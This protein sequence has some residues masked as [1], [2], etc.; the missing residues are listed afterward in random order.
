MGHRGR[1]LPPAR[2]DGPGECRARGLSARRRP[3]PCI[4][5]VT[6]SIRQLGDASARRRRT[7]SRGRAALPALAERLLGRA[8]ASVARAVS[9]RRPLARVVVNGG[10]CVWPDINWLHAVHAAWP[11]RDDGAPWWSRYRNAPPEADRA[12]R[13]NAPRFRPARI[14][15]ANSEA[16]RRAA[17]DRV[18]V[19]RGRVRTPSISAP[20]PSGACRAPRNG[21]PR[22]P[23]WDCR[24][25]FR[26]CCSSARSATTSTRDSTCCGG[27]GTACRDPGSWDARL[28]VA[29]GGW[30]AAAWQREAE[31][32]TARHGALSRLHAE[33]AR[34]AGGRRICS[35]VPVRYEAY[36]LNVHEALCRGLAV[37]VT[38]DG[39]R[40]RAV[41]R[42]DGAGAAAAGRDRRRPRRSVARVARRRRGMAVARVGDRGTAARA[43]VDD[44]GRGARRGRATSRRARASA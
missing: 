24:R 20:I 22:A 36:G 43:V 27:P 29:G 17:I 42:G 1:R 30:R 10:N 23:H 19:A 35:S 4:S 32:S 11:V 7:W 15:I 16:T 28:V 14:V 2:R 9:R 41:R 21:P 12:S 44:D 33:R 18:G 39:G 38:R 6:R 40:R 25:M 8:G 37:M 26:W 31:R 3:C 13:A 34:S 5:S